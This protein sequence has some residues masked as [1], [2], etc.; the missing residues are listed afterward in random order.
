MHPINPLIFDHL[1]INQR[2]MYLRK[3]LLTETKKRAILW[4]DIDVII[5]PFELKLLS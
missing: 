3:N 5:Y 2:E 4:D 1:S